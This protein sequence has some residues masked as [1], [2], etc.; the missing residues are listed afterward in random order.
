VGLLK[1][2]ARGNAELELVVT[3][4]QLPFSGAT[5]RKFI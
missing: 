5:T 2:A 4:E 3:F 1:K